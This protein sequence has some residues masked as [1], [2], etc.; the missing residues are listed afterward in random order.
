MSKQQQE[1]AN[2]EIVKSWVFQ[3]LKARDLTLDEWR[4]LVLWSAPEQGRFSTLTLTLA[5]AE[6][7]RQ[8]FLGRCLGLDDVAALG[9]CRVKGLFQEEVFSGKRLFLWRSL[10]RDPEDALIVPT[11]SLLNGVLTTIWCWVEDPDQLLYGF[12]RTPLLPA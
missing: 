8:E 3:D 11:L 10:A 4:S 9:V 5:Y 7:V 12:D 6:L 2:A 1:Q